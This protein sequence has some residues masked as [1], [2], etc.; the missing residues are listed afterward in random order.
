MTMIAVGQGLRGIANR[1][2]SAVSRAEAVEEQQRMGI[3]AQKKA[4]EAQTMGTG[5]GIGGMYGATKLAKAG[6]TATESVG[7]LNTSIQGLGTAG[8]KGGQLTFTP[9]VEGAKTLTGT[10][11]TTALESATGIVDAGAA[12]G[13]TGTGA[14]GTGA[15]GTGAVGTGAVGTG[16]VG[17][18][19]VGTGAVGTGAVGTTA[20]GTLG[21]ATTAAAS[22]GP[23][24]ALSTLAAPIAIGL[25]VSYLINKLFG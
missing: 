24:A 23:M 13:S 3:E 22:T 1:G 18:G 15:V 25:G 6:A 4:A 5:A 16:A 9:A 14:V 17:T 7:A 10:S 21:T 12:L 19:A 20:T 2:M 8:M 11:A